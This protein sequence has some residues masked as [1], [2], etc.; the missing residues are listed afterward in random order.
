MLNVAPLN[1]AYPGS[2][3]H[4][5]GAGREVCCYG[6]DRRDRGRLNYLVTRWLPV[7]ALTVLCRSNGHLSCSA[8]Q[9]LADWLPALY[10]L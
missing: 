7:P 5:G 8:N 1:G 6:Q 3:A 2:S 10:S 4:H 9:P